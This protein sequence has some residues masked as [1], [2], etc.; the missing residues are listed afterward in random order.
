M[1]NRIA[2]MK[3]VITHKNNY[4]AHYT[5]PKRSGGYRQITTP[6]SDLKYLQKE[7]LWNIL[8]HINVHF[9]ATGF[10]KGQSIYTNAQRHLGAI[11]IVNLDLKDFFPSVTTEMIVERISK[12]INSPH[13]FTE[14]VTFNGCLPQGAPTSPC[15]SNIMCIDMDKKLYNLAKNNKAKYSRYAD[16]MT[17]SS[18]KNNHLDKI[19]P[20]A[21]S[22]IKQADFT[23]NYKKI[24]V[25]RKGCRQVVTGLVVND[26][27]NVPRK[28]LRNF[29]AELHQKKLNGASINDVHRMKGYT[30]FVSSVN[31]EKGEKFKID[32][33][34]MTQ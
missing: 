22:I 4:Y 5:I 16:D 12:Y 10:R 30:A 6:T 32:I 21:H 25:M 33:E 2:L 28:K 17:F 26:K 20:K 29:R 3:D 24:N 31:P 23:L 8:N 34:E 15:I 18:K 14:L 9:T 27:V 1:V 13:A 19:I 7:L 11:C